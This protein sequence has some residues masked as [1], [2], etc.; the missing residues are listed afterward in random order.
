[1]KKYPYFTCS[2]TIESEEDIFGVAKIEELTPK[3]LLHLFST[4]AFGPFSNPTTT[5]FF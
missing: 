2:I 4:K 3:K 1:M 5:F